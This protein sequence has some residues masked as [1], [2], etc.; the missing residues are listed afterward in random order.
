M[1]LKEIILLLFIGF[2]FL[3]DSSISQEY[4]KERNY[5]KKRE[6]NL[7]KKKLRNRHMDG[8]NFNLGT[9]DVSDKPYVHPLHWNHLVGKFGEQ[10]MSIIQRERPDLNVRIVS[11]VSDFIIIIVI[12]DLTLLFMTM[13]LLLQLL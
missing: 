4:L 8:D 12:F 13:L 2:L 6:L 3:F 1:A 5:R 11:E 7:H 10:A 9:P